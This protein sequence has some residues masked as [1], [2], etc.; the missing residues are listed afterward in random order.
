[1]HP[2]QLLDTLISPTIQSI[3]WQFAAFP[4]GKFISQI[5]TLNPHSINEHFSLN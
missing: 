5:S 4:E 3:K 1:M 2:N